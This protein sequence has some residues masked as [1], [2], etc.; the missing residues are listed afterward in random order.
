MLKWLLLAVFFIFPLSGYAQA[1]SGAVPAFEPNLRVGILTNQHTIEVSADA[2]F[3]IV[4]TDAA[5]VLGSFG[6]NDTVT[7]AVRE[8]GFTIND[9]PVKATGLAVVKKKEHA[10]VSSEHYL[11]ANKRRYRGDLSVHR[12][13]GKPG[14]TMVN[15]LPVEQYL[16]GVIKNE[17][18]PEWAK[19]AVKAQAVA[20]RTYALAN[21]NKHKAD[22]F[23]I[24]ST[25]D[26]QVYGGR[27]SEAPKAIDAVNTTR[28]L[29]LTYK[30]KLIT[31]YFHSSSGG[32]TEN[33]ENVWSSEQPYLR[34]VADF[35]QDSPYYKWEKKL[36]LAELTQV[37]TEA[38]YNI[39][40]LQAIELSP[41]AI[42]PIVS[43][44]RGVSG[45]VKTLYLKGT[46]GNIQITGTKLRNMLN[47]KSTLFDITV[48]K[49]HHELTM[50]ISA[51]KDNKPA[52]SSG[53]LALTRKKSSNLSPLTVAP[54]D[55]IVITG[56]GWG[57][58]LGL[59]QWGAK[60]MAE[61]GPAGN[62]EYFK[63]ILKHYYQAVEI[64][65]AY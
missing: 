62:T 31:A 21:V 55:Y 1:G 64:K 41:L 44:D 59:S 46:T 39:G 63:D 61:K 25:T 16:Y 42:P 47:L 20:A 49:G 13:I 5:K 32:Y 10:L 9:R 53:M 56:F 15:T 11:Y 6:A 52:Q 48:I 3:D 43:P 58:G 22:G 45:R 60:A 4:S 30:D 12:T 36:T 19:E 26:C 29:V 24:C 65:K 14:M 34:G 40:Y 7:I 18:S 17:I 50:P 27:E 23:D 28:G 57:H 51:S 54:T 37:I 33:S 2:K 35:D 38:G 8:S